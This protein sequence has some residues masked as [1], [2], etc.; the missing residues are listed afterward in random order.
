MFFNDTLTFQARTLGTPDAFGH[1]DE[2]F[3]E[4][5]IYCRA[6]PRLEGNRKPSE[7]HTG[8]YG[9]LVREGISIGVPRHETVAERDEVSSLIVEGEEW[10]KEETRLE[11]RTVIQYRNYQEM[12]C[13]VIR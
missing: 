13:E 7:A 2:T 9:T 11:V 6:W 5:T 8:S 3:V 1:Q 10:L 12:Q 4:R